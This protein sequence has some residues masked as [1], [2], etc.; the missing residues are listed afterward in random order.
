MLTNRRDFLVS[1]DIETTGLLDE[2]GSTILEIGAHLVDFATLRQAG[3][4]HRVV[5]HK[6]DPAKPCSYF[7]TE[8]HKKNGLWADCEKSV[9]SLHEALVDFRSWSDPLEGCTLLG[10][11]VGT[12]DRIFME[13][14]LPRC[15]SGY[16][17]RH[18]D[19]SSIGLLKRHSKL[20]E[21][22]W[23]AEIEKLRAPGAPEVE[24]RALPDAWLAVMDLRALLEII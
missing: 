21:A 8:M 3:Q 9:V 12:F 2:E 16:D 1:L 7:V 11:N 20:F 4:F 23:A 22:G 5:H 19:L 6:R 13:R 18:L 15:T 24:H 10:R 14:F 17:H